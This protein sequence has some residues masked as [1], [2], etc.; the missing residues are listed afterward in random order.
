MDE[1]TQAMAAMAAGFVADTAFR[2]LG[3]VIIALLINAGLFS[4]ICRRGEKAIGLCITKGIDAIEDAAKIYVE[5]GG[6]RGTVWPLTLL[7]L[8]IGMS[9]VWV[10]VTIIRP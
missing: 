1:T 3:F 7:L 9:G 10:S 2:H 6:E 8:A 4:F 5:S